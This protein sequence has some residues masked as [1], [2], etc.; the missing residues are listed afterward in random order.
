MANQIAA[1]TR[2]KK[3]EHRL[4]KK[5]RLIKIDHGKLKQTGEGASD[6]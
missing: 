1:M 5:P 6:Q 4:L 2:S 3:R